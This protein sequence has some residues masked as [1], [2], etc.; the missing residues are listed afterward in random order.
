MT[1]PTKNKALRTVHL[2][3][4]AR[5]RKNKKHRKTRR[6]WGISKT[7]KTVRKPEKPE[8]TE[9]PETIGHIQLNSLQTFWFFWFSQVFLVSRLCTIQ[10]T[11]LQTFWFFCF[12]GFLLVVSGFWPL[13][14]AQYSLLCM[15][16]S[17]VFWSATVA[18]LLPHQWLAKISPSISSRKSARATSVAKFVSANLP[19]GNF[20]VATFDNAASHFF[21]LVEHKKDINIAEL[22]HLQ[23]LP[24]PFGL[25]EKV[26]DDTLLQM[27]ITQGQDGHHYILK[28]FMLPVFEKMA[29]GKCFRP[30]WMSGAQFARV[31]KYSI[32]LVPDGR[33]AAHRVRAH[34][35]S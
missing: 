29:Y 8:K 10:L 12:S 17:K 21:D 7:R 2:L 30:L 16:S 19:P 25:K 11:S 13:Y 28:H 9:D 35:P 6:Q 4:Q 24:P 14:V 33:W 34:H 23:M 27:V 3:H 31:G 22:S 1:K 32:L 26:G 5:T 18:N 20:N 15:I